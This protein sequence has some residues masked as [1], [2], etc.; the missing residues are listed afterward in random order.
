MK[1]VL[2]IFAVVFLLISC[3][4]GDLVFENI[5]FDDVTANKC[6]NKIYKLNGE[7]A[8]ILKI[9]SSVT[10]ENFL[11]AFPDEPTT[12]GQPTSIT[13]NN[14]TN[15]VVYRLYDGQVENENICDAIPA[16]F[17]NIR[18]E[19]EATSGTIEIITTMIIAENTAVGFEGGQKITGYQNNIVFKNITFRKADGTTQVYDEF[20]FGIFTKAASTTLPFNF[21]DIALQKCPSSSIVFKT[22][23]T[24]AFSIN[25]DPTLLDSNSLG[26]VKT[27]VVSADLNA[28]NYYIFATGTVINAELLCAATPA[29]S[30]THRWVGVDGEANFSGLVEVVSAALPGGNGFSYTIRLKK[31]TL[32]KGRNEFVLADNYLFGTLIVPN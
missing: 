16:A 8:L 30:P 2:G 29:V 28:V 21:G 5:N 27:G 17:P 4:D 24:E 20:P 31:V 10:D 11:S 9:G 22:I 15:K 32:K 25:L 3:D 23:G 6:D 1:K 18:E 7:E 19:W 26:V 13:I 14:S 12:V